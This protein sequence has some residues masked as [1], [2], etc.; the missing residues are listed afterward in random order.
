MTNDYLLLGICSAFLTC[1]TSFDYTFCSSYKNKNKVIVTLKT[2]IQEQ[3]QCF[4]L[5][6][7]LFTW[8]HYF[9]GTILMAISFDSK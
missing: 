7:L 9:G 8:M 5:I 6:L 3:H 4:K 2:K 1:L